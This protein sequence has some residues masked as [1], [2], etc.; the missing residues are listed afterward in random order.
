[1]VAGLPIMATLLVWKCFQVVLPRKV[2]AEYDSDDGADD[3]EE[4]DAASSSESTVGLTV[5][6]AILSL[7][8]G[9]RKR[10]RGCDLAVVGASMEGFYDSSG[11]QVCKPQ[12]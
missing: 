12:R 7:D 10:L 9:V 5:R 11:I 6:T 8:E 3:V 2:D 4:P 1:M